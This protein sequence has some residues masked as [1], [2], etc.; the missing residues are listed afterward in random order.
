MPRRRS[1]AYAVVPAPMFVG[2]PDHPSP[3]RFGSAFVAKFQLRGS[4][5]P[6]QSSFAVLRPEAHWLLPASNAQARL[7]GLRPIFCFEL[8]LHIRRSRLEE[9]NSLRSNHR[10]RCA[11]LTPLFDELFDRQLLFATRIEQRPPPDFIHLQKKFFKIGV[12][13]TRCRDK[14]RDRLIVFGGL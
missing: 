9:T 4:Q 5:K 13:G 2:P 1:T 8:P 10:P 7:R 3:N 11:S 14:L 12:T 6:H